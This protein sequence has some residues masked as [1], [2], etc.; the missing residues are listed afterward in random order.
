LKHVETHGFIRTT[1]VKPLVTSALQGLRPSQLALAAELYA[2]KGGWGH[3]WDGRN[4]A[5]A[6]VETC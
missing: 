4:P 3:G 2:A 6:A 5:P 1:E